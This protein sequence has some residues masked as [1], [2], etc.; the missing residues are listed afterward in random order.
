MV[1]AARIGAPYEESVA[2]LR[3]LLE[4]DIV[5]HALAE[6]E[7]LYAAATEPTLTPLVTGMVFEHQT[8]HALAADLAAAS[9]AVDAV[10]AAA[11]IRAVFIGHV[12]R[13]NDLLLPALAV[14]PDVDLPALLPRMREQM[15][16]HQATDS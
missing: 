13:E 14:D 5:P 4:H 2:A 11:A 16:V 8:L 3:G 6:E 7:V 10:A 9:T 12:R 15:T 1:N